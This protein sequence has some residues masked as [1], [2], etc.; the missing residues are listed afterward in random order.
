M[1]SSTRR[2][3]NVALLAAAPAVL[4]TLAACAVGGIPQPAPG[5]GAPATTACPAGRQRRGRARPV[6]RRDGRARPGERAT[7]IR[8]GRGTQL[9]VVPPRGV[10]LPPSGRES[11]VMPMPYEFGC[12]TTVFVGASHD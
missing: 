2:P 7:L 11:E 3:L 10:V 4:V 6:Q 8:D 1:S 12:S 9:V 5:Q